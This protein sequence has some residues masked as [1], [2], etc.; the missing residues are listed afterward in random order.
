[1]GEDPE[2]R[3]H[4]LLHGSLLRLQPGKRVGRGKRAREED[5]S[6]A[7]RYTGQEALDRLETLKYKDDYAEEG[8]I[9]SSAETLN[10]GPLTGDSP[11]RIMFVSCIIC[12]S[13]ERIRHEI[14]HVLQLFATRM[15]SV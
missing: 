1:M 9:L 3:R 8:Y 7:V 14:R 13:T 4:Y 10:S 5:C 15:F 11:P 12:S 2:Q 6:V